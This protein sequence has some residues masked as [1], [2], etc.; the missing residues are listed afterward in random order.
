[1]QTGVMTEELV[2]VILV[3]LLESAEDPKYSVIRG[4][5]LETL[6]ALLESL[7]LSLST[8]QFQ[9]IEQ[10]LNRF[11]DVTLHEKIGKLKSLLKDYPP[12]K[13]QKN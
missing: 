7:G 11:G 10:M 1:M 2:E 6:E 9:N 5:A 13:R 8:K 12:A 4:A 3:P